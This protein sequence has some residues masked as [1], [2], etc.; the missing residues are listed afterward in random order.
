M[1]TEKLLKAEE[2]Y[3]ATQ[4][5]ASYSELAAQVGVNKRTVVRWAQKYHWRARVAELAALVQEKVTDK[6]AESLADRAAALAESSL[7]PLERINALVSARLDNPTLD[8]EHLRPA[9]LRALALAQ[10]S[11]IKNARLLS[12]EPT[13]HEQLSG[14]L[15]LEIETNGYID[16][17][18]QKIIR[19]GDVE[20]Q[21]RLLRLQEALQDLI[22]DKD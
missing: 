21:F 17:I 7:L 1:K 6:L 9:D 5:R 19:T 15:S 20:G 12:G 4:G 13:S 2:T 3:F 11:V 14:Q 18:I 10:D 16:E 8:T 22:E